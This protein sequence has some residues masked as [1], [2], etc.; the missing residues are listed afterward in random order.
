MEN[1]SNSLNHYFE[2]NQ[3]LT[4]ES[5]IRATFAN[6]ERKKFAQSKINRYSHPLHA[7]ST[8]SEDLIQRITSEMPVAL[9]NFNQKAIQVVDTS[10]LKQSVD[11]V[12]WIATLKTL[13]WF[14]PFSSK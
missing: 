6:P 10:K 2:T 12:E 7:G 5:I 9:S 8:D 14:G 4:V 1:E 11:K 13:K 3:T